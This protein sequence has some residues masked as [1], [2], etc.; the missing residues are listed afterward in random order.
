MRLGERG[1]EWWGVRA[2]GGRDPERERAR[3]REQVRG[4]KIAKTGQRREGDSKREME[5][6]T[7]IKGGDRTREREGGKEQQREVK[8]VR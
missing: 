5:R 4:G 8:R 3:V 1:R 6:E 2:R 7:E